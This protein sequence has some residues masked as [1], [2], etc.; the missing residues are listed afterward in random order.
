[1]FSAAYLEALRDV[2]EIEPEDAAVLARRLAK[3]PDDS[4]ARLKLIAYS[5]RADRAGLSESRNQRAQLVFWL[6]EH[7]PDSEILGSPYAIFSAG[8]L[9]PDQVQ[10]AMRL[11]KSATEK[12][13]SDARVMW[14]AANFYRV[15]DRGLHVAFLERAVVLAPGNENYAR[16]L[17]LLYAGVILTANPQ[18]MYRDP[19]GADPAL[20]RRAAHELDNT[21][22]AFVLEAAVRLFQSE[23]NR[24]QML[25]KANAS[26]GELAQRYFQRAKALDPD[27]DEAWIFPKIDPKMI[28]ML[29]PG[30]RPPEADRAKFDTAEKEIRRLPLEAFPELP[31][32]VRV[33]LST[34]GCLVS[35][36][37]L[38]GPPRNVIRGEF[39]DK[40]RIGWAVL[41]STGGSSSILVFR[42]DSDTRP[43]EL[44]RSEDKVYLQGVGEGKIA[45]SR[46][47]QAVDRKFIM[48][49]YRAYGGPEPPPVNH[50]GI[51]DAFLGKA[52]VTHYW[53]NGKWLQLQG[54]D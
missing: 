47:I 37:T 15:Y 21:Q 43:E 14:N 32:S 10:R 48:A 38:D 12:R 13:Q 44:A 17:G 1:M 31:H 52:S 9:T 51:D 7:R 18:S 39:L 4:A 49:H 20:A 26:P 22:N 54:S 34:R 2:L 50:Q 28:G 24:S 35:Q 11:W 6:V 33:V 16:E 36:P 29:A 30:A 46:E 25:G 19:A 53:H 40:G 27:L 3:D 8:D 41:C 23:Y 5:M 42:D 45:F